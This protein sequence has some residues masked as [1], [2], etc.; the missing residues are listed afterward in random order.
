LTLGSLGKRMVRFRIPDARSD[1][2]VIAVLRA[3]QRVSSAQPN[4]RYYLPDR[5]PIEISGLKEQPQAKAI[6]EKRLASAQRR[7]DGKTV[8]AL[9]RSGS[10]VAGNHMSLR[11]PTADEPFVNVGMRNR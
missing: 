11:W 7:G 5:S 1:T 6:K 4:Y 8:P 2:D 3:D 9:Q 10:L